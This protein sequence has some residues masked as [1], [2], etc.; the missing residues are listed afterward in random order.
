MT[1]DPILSPM[2]QK[3][4]QPFNK[5]ICKPFMII[6]CI[7]I[8]IQY[9]HYI[10]NPLWLS[11]RVYVSHI[12]NHAPDVIFQQLLWLGWWGCI[13]VDGILWSHTWTPKTNPWEFG[14]N[15]AYEI[16]ELLNGGEKGRC[17]QIFR[18][19]CEVVLLLNKTQTLMFGS[20]SNPGRTQ[21]FDVCFFCW[22][23]ICMHW[24]HMCEI[25]NSMK[26]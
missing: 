5:L 11:P 15:L 16:L 10:M 21:R 3:S 26:L 13:E 20:S 6:I 14:H 17:L 12:F 1:R 8:Y 9:I 4:S 23:T 2:V 7:Y 25:H 22:R 18:W 24:Q 19:V